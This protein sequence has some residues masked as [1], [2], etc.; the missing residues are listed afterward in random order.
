MIFSRLF[1]AKRVVAGACAML[2]AASVRVG[3]QAPA[4]GAQP[5]TGTA[6]SKPYQPPRTPWGDPDLQGVYKN[7]SMYPLEAFERPANE[8]QAPRRVDAGAG[9]EHWYE[10]PMNGR[11]PMVE[12]PANHRVPYK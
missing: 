9:P 6:A 3:A 10:V 8:G 5:T 12:E 4:A 7:Y 1:T 2:F 11:T